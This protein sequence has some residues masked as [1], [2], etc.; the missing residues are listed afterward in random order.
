MKSA[1]TLLI[2]TLCLLLAPITLAAQ[3]APV[4][5]PFEKGTTAPPAD[6][7]AVPA[8]GEVVPAEGE[9]VPAEGEAV[10]AEGEAVPAESEGVQT[11]GNTDIQ[12]T[13]APPMTVTIL[14]EGEATGPQRFAYGKFEFVPVPEEELSGAEITAF[15]LVGFALPT[16]ATGGVLM[17][18]DERTIGGACVG[19]GAALM[20][21]GGA[22]FYWADL[23]A[24]QSE[25]EPYVIPTISLGPEGPRVSGLARF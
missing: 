5:D 16:L 24:A 25:A 19:S 23:T 8:E 2:V 14:P 12:D 15:L 17:S 1:S 20:M 7:A 18:Q 9:E 6:G 4:V 11:E 10:P 13:A 22:L 3:D 21:A